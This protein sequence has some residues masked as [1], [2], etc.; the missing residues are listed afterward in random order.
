M[1]VYIAWDNNDVNSLDESEN[2]EPN[3]C[4]LENYEDEV[5]SLELEYDL[6]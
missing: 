2:E 6:T 4:F 1:K 3:L 5:N